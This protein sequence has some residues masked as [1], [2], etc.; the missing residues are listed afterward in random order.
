MIWVHF[1]VNARRIIKGI[2][3]SFFWANYERIWWNN[4]YHDHYPNQVGQDVDS[5]LF[6]IMVKNLV[7]V[8]KLWEKHIAYTRTYPGTTIS[9]SNTRKPV[10]PK[11]DNKM[12]ITIF[13]TGAFGTKISLWYVP[14]ALQ[15][16]VVL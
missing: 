6:L 2:I 8:T 5:I 14:V 9:K 16:T 11:I 3:Q 12:D 7:R 10:E 1:V 15:Y 13:S 4:Y